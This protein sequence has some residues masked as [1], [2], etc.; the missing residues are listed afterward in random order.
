MT[1]TIL[2]IDDDP[3][4]LRLTELNLTKAG[5][6]FVSAQHGIAGLQMLERE[7][8]SLVLLD[9]SMPKLDGWET[10]RLIREVSDV[11]I[12][13]LTGRDEETDKARGLDLG[14]DDYLTKPFGFVELEARI[15]ALLRR[16]IMPSVKENRKLQSSFR[17]GGLV[18]DIAA[19]QVTR[20]GKPVVLTP[21]E[22]RLLEHL[23]KHAGMVLTHSQLLTAVWGFAYS[24]ATE[25]LKP[26]I[27]RLRQKVEEDPSHPTLIQTVHGVGYRLMLTPNM[28]NEQ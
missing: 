20:Q 4:L 10:C 26:V 22:F 21:T 28:R 16:A 9:V 15:R 17:S 19:H 12:L 14:A 11:P 7:H 13:M 1:E 24:E 27:S 23:L 2:M 8:P 6:G 25:L 18:V 5:Y 3:A